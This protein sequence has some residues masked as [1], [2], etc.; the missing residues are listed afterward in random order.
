[1]SLSTQPTAL[2]AGLVGC[3]AI[4]SR[5]P[6]A[7]E[8]AGF[9]VARVFD[10]DEARATAISTRYGIARAPSLDALLDAPLDVVCICTPN[11]T[12][13]WIA[14]LALR[15]GHHVVVEHPMGVTL[16][17]ARS[18]VQ[19]ATQAQRRLFVVRQRRFLPTIQAVREALRLRRLGRVTSVE[20]SVSWSRSPE[21]FASPGRAEVGSGGVVMNQ[22]SHFLDIL[23]YLFGD[24]VGGIGVRGNMRHK[25]AVEDTVYGRLSFRD[26]IA[27]TIFFSV[28]GQESLGASRLLIEGTD[29]CIALGG[30]GWDLVAEWTVPGRPADDSSRG[31]HRDFLSRV[32]ATLLG[33]DVESVEAV[34]G[35]RAA[36]LIERILRT[37]PLDSL[38]LQARRFHPRFGEKIVFDDGSECGGS[39]TNSPT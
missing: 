38:D 23:L 27:A 33:A 9:R 32:K 14:G 25:L 6:S 20:A 31:D 34:Q 15:A 19:Q 3:G 8:S 7:L 12:H 36:E 21:Y 13:E 2:I 39:P 26:D 28:A 24:P 4:G 18:L 10:I 22:A 1:M 17:E 11:V 29:G 5:Y 30:K 16:Q 35:V 37:F